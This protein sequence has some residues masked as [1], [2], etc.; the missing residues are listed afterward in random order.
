MSKSTTLADYLMLP[1][2]I[3][4]KAIVFTYSALWKLVL[5]ALPILALVA[6]VMGAN[7]LLNQGRQP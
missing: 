1:W 3:F 7:R 2:S 5:F 6:L 4:G